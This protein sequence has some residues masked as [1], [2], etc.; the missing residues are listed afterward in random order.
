MVDRLPS[1][2]LEERRRGLQFADWHESLTKARGAMRAELDQQSACR[3]VADRVDLQRLR[4]ALENWPRGGWEQPH[5]SHLYRV[6]LLR[7][8]SAGHFV[9]HVL[10]NGR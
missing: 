7:S 6:V 10:E 2:I 5:T 3:A 9:R 4:D 1:M 8:L